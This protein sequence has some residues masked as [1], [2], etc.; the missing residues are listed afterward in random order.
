MPKEIRELSQDH[1]GRK[2]QDANPELRIKFS[3]LLLFSNSV[4]SDSLWPHGLQHI[5]L[6]CPSLSPRD[7][8][9]SC[10][11]SWWC[12]PTVSSSVARFSSYPQSFAESGSFPM[13]QLFTPGD[14][15]TGASASAS[16]LPVNTQSW[17]LLVLTDLI[18]LLSKGLSGVFSSTTVWKHQFFGAQPS[19][20]S[21]SHMHTWLWIFVSEVMPLLFNMLSRLVVVFPPRSKHLL[22]SWLKS[23]SA[24]ILEPK[25]I[26]SVTVSIVSHLFAMKWW[27]WMPGSYFFECWVLSQLFHSPLSLPSRVSLFL[28]TFCHRVVSSLHLWLLKFFP[29]SW[30]QLVLYPAWDFSWCTLHIS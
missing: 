30:F 10:P 21:N 29:S 11:S 28:F 24:V 25:K 3:A 16:V 6:S 22:I 17:F 23:S 8:S 12:H 20:W 2:W 5:R 7:C 14:Q 15:S 27:D 26:K 9:N 13:N 4:V 1:R 18:S 19:L